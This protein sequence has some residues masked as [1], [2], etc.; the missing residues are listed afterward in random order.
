MASHSSA[1]PGAAPRDA[2]HSRAYLRG[3]SRIRK[4]VTH[5]VRS[6]LHGLSLTA[7]VLG[8]LG[9]QPVNGGAGAWARV[10]RDARLLA[11]EL[12]QLGEELE[13]LLQQLDVEPGEAAALDLGDAL[14]DSTRWLATFAR[15]RGVTWTVQAPESPVT[16]VAEAAALRRALFHLGCESIERATAGAT[17]DLRVAA[18]P[19]EAVLT[20]AGVDLAIAGALAAR[21]AS[22]HDAGIAA[23]RDG[24]ESVGG[25]IV[26]AAGPERSLEIRWR[27]AAGGD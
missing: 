19:P 12:R 4:A 6:R 13:H 17:L 21:D 16:L 23:V 3:L 10:E 27:L 9:R 25:R 1:P 26:P 15:M 14:R 20:L 2:V 24:L 7:E 18:A 5:D 11:A 8:E 22:D